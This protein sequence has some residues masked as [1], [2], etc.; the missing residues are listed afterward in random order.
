MSNNQKK[1]KKNNTNKPQT[2][3]KANTEVKEKEEVKV[4]VEEAKATPKKEE[5]K[6]AKTEAKKVEKKETKKEEKKV[7]E[8]KEVKKDEEKKAEVKISKVNTDKVVIFSIVGFCILVALGVFFFVFYKSNYE[9]VVDTD[10]GMV[11]KNEYT[12]YYKMFAPMLEYYGYKSTQIPSVIANKAGTD[13]IILAKA[14]E[15]NVTLS[16]EDKAAIDKVFSDKDQISTWQQS[17]INIS[18]LRKLYE[19][20]YIITA[21]INKL[22]KDASDEDILKYIKETYGENAD[23]YEYNTRHILLK[24]TTTGEDGTS[25]KMSDEQ[26]ATVFAKAQGLLARALAGEDFAT[27]AKENSEDGTASDGGA[28][29]FYDGDSIYEEY[30][31]A[32]KSLEAG[33]VYAQ[34][35]ETEAGYHII[36]L[37]SKVEN[38]RSKSSTIRSSYANEKVNN[39]STSEKIDIKTDVLNKL[40]ETI[41]GVATTTETDDNTSDTDDSTDASTQSTDSTTQESTQEETPVVT[42]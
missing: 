24:T 17:G 42:E 2:A 38:G 9:A 20:D 29:T 4:E 22:A 3:K 6:V 36:K 8:V 11:N 40:V 26:K 35:V 18:I 34:I 28:F 15:A 33:Q 13:K 21:Y 16:D 12:V 1:S 25:S 32:S 7:E 39:L 27:L 41:T 14:K 31:K 5:K 10:Y 23:L 30:E 37:D 19:E